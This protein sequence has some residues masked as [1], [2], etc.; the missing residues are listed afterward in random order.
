M[1]ATVPDMVAAHI[2]ALRPHLRTAP[3]PL[4]LDGGVVEL[5]WPAARDDDE[6]CRF[7]RKHLAAI[8][9]REARPGRR[10]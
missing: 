5:L 9:A 3:V 4:P 2:C 10:R 6:P 7:L 8:A 1:I